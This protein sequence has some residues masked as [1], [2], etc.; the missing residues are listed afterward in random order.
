MTNSMINPVHT[1]ALVVG[2]EKYTLGS[3]ADLNG[4]AHDACTFAA[5]LAARG[6]PQENVVLLLSPLDESSNLLDEWP[7]PYKWP[8]TREKVDFVINQMLRQWTGD[9]FYVYW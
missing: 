1:Y 9:L 2:I 7:G 4:P 8:A 6:V 3:E 5:W